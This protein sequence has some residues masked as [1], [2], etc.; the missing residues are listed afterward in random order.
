MMTGE[1]EEDETQLEVTLE[2]SVSA[3]YGEKIDRTF[4]M[5]ALMIVA[6]PTILLPAKQ[7]TSFRSRCITAQDFASHYQME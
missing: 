4:Q 6:A 3:I 7:P 5:R 1:D 2:M